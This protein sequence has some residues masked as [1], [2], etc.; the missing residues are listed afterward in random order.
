MIWP[1]SL[2]LPP[3]SITA[4]AGCLC[5]FMQL[6]AAS[7]NVGGSEPSDQP[8]CR[9]PGQPRT[10]ATGTSP[11]RQNPS[12]NNPSVTDESKSKHTNKLVEQE[13]EK[14][15]TSQV[16]HQYS[17]KSPNLHLQNG[18]SGAF[19]EPLEVPPLLPNVLN[20]GAS[21]AAQVPQ[22]KP[23]TSITA[24]GSSSDAD[25]SDD[26]LHNGDANEEEALQYCKNERK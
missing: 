9:L 26:D 22:P 20:L 1:V 21:N 13:K 17:E 5:F 11:V 15:V 25:L 18:F 23:D 3:L 4:S 6:E 7:L 8:Q 10:P 2:F 16:E 24:T 14:L 12:V 19:Q